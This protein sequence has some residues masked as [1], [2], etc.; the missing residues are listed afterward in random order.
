MI[1]VASVQGTT[2]VL[3]NATDSIRSALQGYRPAIDSQ[4]RTVVSLESAGQLPALFGTLR[5][6]GVGF[7]G[8][9]HGWPPAEIFAELRE[10]SLVEGPFD[11]VVFSG[12]EMP[13]RRSR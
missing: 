12:P 7:A 3:V 13:I 8:G 9:T 4:G 6:L 11:E 10:K 1:Y 2:V 5:D